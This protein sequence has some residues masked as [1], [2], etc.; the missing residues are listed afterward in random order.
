LALIALAL[1]SVAE[2]QGLRRGGTLR[3]ANIGEPP[4]LD[5][6]ATTVGITGNIG[7]AICGPSP[8]WSRATR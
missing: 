4:T 5:T 2:P 6:S 1:G 7:N 8:C 3:I